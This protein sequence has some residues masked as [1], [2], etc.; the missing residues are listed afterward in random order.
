MPLRRS[1]PLV[2]PLVSVGLWLATQLAG[3]KSEHV[4]EPPPDAGR[5]A[6][7]SCVALTP[8]PESG[9]VRLERVYG[10]A[11]SG[12]SA[13][14][15][16]HVIP[17]TAAHPGFVTRQSGRVLAF[18][19]QDSSAASVVLDI[20]SRLDLSSAENGLVSMALAPDFV[21]SGFAYFVYTAPPAGMGRYIARVARYHWTGSAFDDASEL[22]ILEIPQPDITHSVNHVAFGL[23]GMLYIS[24]GDQRRT[25]VNA[26]SLLTLPGKVLR[27][28]V[29]VAQLG[30]PYRIPMDNPFVGEGAGEIY[31]LGLRNPWR[32]TID[33]VDGEILLGD[34]GQDRREEIDRIVAG[35]NYGWPARE[36]TLCFR[37][38]PCVDAAFTDPLVE[39]SHAEAR[40][41]VAGYRY[42]RTD[43]AGLQGSVVFADYV[44][45]N[46]WSADASGQARLEVEGRFPISSIGL[47][48]E[49]RP[50]FTRYDGSADGGLYRLVPNVPAPSSFPT[51]LSATGC[52]D[53]ADP[54]EPA[55]GMVRFTPTAELWSDGAEKL[56]AFAIPDGTAI[57]VDGDGDLLLPVGSVLLKH[58]GFA[59]RLHETRLMMRTDDGWTGYSYRW[60]D[61]QTDAELL[62]TAVSEVLENG[63]RWQYPSRSACFECHTDAAGTTLG[64]EAAQLSDAALQGLLDL[65]YVDRRVTTVG[66]LRG[67]SRAPLVPPFGA[68]PVAERARSYLHV[69]CSG[70][71]RPGGPGRGDIDLRAETPFGATRLCNA[72]PGEGRIWDVGVWDEQRN[73]V[74][75]E[76]GYSILYL[77]MNTLGIFRMPPLGTDVVHAEGT[78]LMAE[79]IESLSACP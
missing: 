51:L 46:V 77:R 63:V 38:D 36:G 69:N 60:N 61:A 2:P 13:Q 65:G 68:A 11:L 53:P 21:Q 19:A 12:A 49:G 50:Y 66:A 52:V 40:A 48:E 20:A 7:T 6:N 47:D 9:R 43:V 42:R 39:L 70:C 56:R 24:L 37:T 17:P 34:V 35:G 3:C 41:V 75:G 45:G 18:D 10:T 29:S 79:W 44:S 59:G 15:L 30:E 74:P 28:D 22:V 54:R 62:P 64:F 26:Q 5:P 67:T 33:P 27:I 8:P 23:D 76:P 25:D 72:E 4:V 78:A 73:L 16:T 58:F 57:G 14:K 71:H 55:D 31:A 1:A 32:F